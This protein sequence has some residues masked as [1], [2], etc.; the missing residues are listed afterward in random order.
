VTLQP[1][2]STA[3]GTR[4]RAPWDT[5]A[6]LAG[7]ALLAL[8]L[9]GAWRARTEARLA[10]GRLAEVRRE[11]EAAS[12]RLRALEA[13]ARG[14]ARGFLPAAQAP[15]AQI[16]AG[17]AAALPGDVRLE[18]LSIDYARGGAIEIHVVARDAAAWDRL[19]ERMEAAPEF[20][21][22]EPGP[23]SREGEVRSVL[24]TRWAVRAR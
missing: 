19:L 9:A 8:A 21:D 13:R 7:T 1:D 20:R 24:R 16:V 11:A 23:E 14:L 22:V 4:R 17:V 3:S 18:R 15:P 2:F 10:R 5:L 6:V 12:G